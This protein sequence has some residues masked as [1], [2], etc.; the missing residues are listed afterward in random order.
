VNAFIW[1]AI[2][3]HHQNLLLNWNIRNRT[4]DQSSVALPSIDEIV[5]LSQNIRG[6][7]HRLE[8]GDYEFEAVREGNIFSREASAAC[9]GRRLVRTS[10]GHFG[11]APETAEPGDQVWLLQCAQ[12]PFVL[13]PRLDGRYSLVGEAYIHGIMFGEAVDCPGGR[14]DFVP[15][16]LV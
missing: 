15:I 14:D 7:D 12:V 4:F 11:L 6:R 13:R 10:H 3:Q 9:W 2:D 1:T 8:T 5:N 16:E